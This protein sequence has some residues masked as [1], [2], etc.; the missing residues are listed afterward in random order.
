MGL[1]GQNE[2]VLAGDAQAIGRAIVEKD[3]L[4]PA[5]KK[6]FCGQSGSAGGTGSQKLAVAWLRHVNSR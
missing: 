3:D 1:F 2:L 5:R 6:L 4:V